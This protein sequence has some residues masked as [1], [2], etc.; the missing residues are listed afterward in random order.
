[1]RIGTVSQAEVD[2]A[3]GRVATD[4]VPDYYTIPGCLIGSGPLQP[5]Q[6][7]CPPNVGPAIP[8]VGTIIPGVPDLVI[9]FAGGLLTLLAL[10]G[11]R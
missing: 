5:G 4:T 6:T 11:G 3:L 1:M 9:Y 7:Y 10:K 2:A 8:P